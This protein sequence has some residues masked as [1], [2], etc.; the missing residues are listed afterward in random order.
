[1]CAG[2]LAGMADPKSYT[3][4]ALSKTNPRN[5][6]GDIMSE[7]WVNLKRFPVVHNKP[8]WCHRLYRP[9][10]CSE[11]CTGMAVLS[12]YLW[13]LWRQI[14]RTTW[15]ISLQNWVR[16]NR[17]QIVNITSF[18]SSLF[19]ELYKNGGLKFISMALVKTNLQNKYGDIMSGSFV[20]LVNGSWHPVFQTVLMHFE[21]FVEG[22]PQPKRWFHVHGPWPIWT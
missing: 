15:E 16:L 12:S 17:F 10:S 5:V 11:S 9:E 20:A 22:V 2:D 3:S 1:M 18:Y 14:Y 8:T 19:R 13:P 21:C 7:L 4:L 6:L